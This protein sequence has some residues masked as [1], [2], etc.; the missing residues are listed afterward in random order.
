MGGKMRRECR[1]N[2]KEADTGYTF[3]FQIADNGARQACSVK[4]QAPNI[5]DAT[6]FFRK[7]WMAVV[8]MAREGL[9]GR[10]RNDGT[11]RLATLIRSPLDGLG[12]PP[13]EFSEEP[14]ALTFD[15]V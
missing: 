7:N 2:N 15:N 6:T 5:D 3:H 4:V 12:R 1:L 11:I 14:Q 10:P 8:S 13:D 9:V